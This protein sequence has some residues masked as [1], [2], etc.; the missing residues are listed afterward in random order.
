[1]EVRSQV[2]SKTEDIDSTLIKGN[3]LHLSS[4]LGR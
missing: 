4:Q 1:M 3:D 2:S